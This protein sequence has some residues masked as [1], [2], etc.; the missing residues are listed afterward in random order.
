[1]GLGPEVKRAAPVDHRPS[2]ELLI[3]KRDGSLMCQ[4][5]GIGIVLL[6]LGRRLFWLVLLCAGFSTG[7]AAWFAGTSFMLDLRSE[8]FS[9]TALVLL[10]SFGGL[11]SA[12]LA[13]TCV[14]SMFGAL[15][16]GW[17]TAY[18]HGCAWLRL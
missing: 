5:G 8:W 1:M 10:P 3:Q 9:C 7:F 11:M 13:Y 2:G 6:L 18:I 15:L 12:Y 16:L 17:K 4:L 14:F